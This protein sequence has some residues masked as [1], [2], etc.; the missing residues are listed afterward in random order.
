MLAPLAPVSAPIS[1]SADR[2]A[3]L[4]ASEAEVVTALPS[5][6]TAPMIGERR[7]TP[8]NSTAAKWIGVAAERPTLRVPLGAVRSGESRT[9]I[10]VRAPLPARVTERV[11]GWPA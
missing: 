10:S 5:A 3:G 6:A 4:N 9:Q 11:N 1:T 7:L 2:V 8:P